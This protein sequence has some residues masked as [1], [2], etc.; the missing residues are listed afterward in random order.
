MNYK[1]QIPNAKY[2][3]TNKQKMLKPKVVISGIGTGGH[4]FPAIVVAKELLR[5]KVEVIFLV[6]KG[7]FE[8]EIARMYGLKTFAINARAFYGK[9]LFCKILS[10]FYIIYS[11]L[12][13]NTMT[14]RVAGIAFGGF[15][16]LPLLISCFINRSSFYLFEPNRIPG[17]ATELFA[18]RAKKI[19]LGLPLATKLKGD[20]IITG[21][22]V[23]R[24]FKTYV[25]D[26]RRKIRSQKQ[27]LFL[28]G[29]QG[30]RRLN[31]LALEIQG[32][33]P[34][35]YQIVII[36][37]KRDFNWVNSRRNGRTKVIPFTSSL[38]EE[39]QDADAI[40]SRS[41]ALAGYE[42]LLS[43]KPV[44][45]IPFPFAVDNHQYYNAGYFTGVG[46]AILLEEKNLTK[47]LLVQRIE[48]RLHTKVK[49]KIK[50][51][52]DAEKRIADVIMK[53]N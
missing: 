8:E 27:I 48:E 22:P 18:S 14:K 47:E 4:Y 20:F 33:L 39:M 30:A 3:M 17:R 51:I 44:V 35:K 2:Q 34:K 23:R 13:L 25:K 38:W 45:F 19:F 29:S 11:V 15:G 5:R 41:G 31:S 6:R 36:C 21:I 9:S 1:C 16:A 10:I 49:K 12:L 40:V 24:E 50:I 37:G 46:D 28:G 52:L 43:N 7:F 53:E 26:Y 32:I 42:I